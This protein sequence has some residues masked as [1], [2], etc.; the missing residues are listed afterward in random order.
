MNWAKVS[1]LLF[2]MTIT[3]GFFSIIPNSFGQN[4]DDSDHD[5]IIDI[6]DNCP[7]TP[8]TSQE[9]TDENGIGDA[10]QDVDGD[11]ILDLEDN[12]PFIPNPTQ[13]DS[14]ENGIGDACENTDLLVV[15]TFPPGD[16]IEI[17]IP[18]EPDT[19][20]GTFT[21]S[22]E[23]PDEDSCVDAEG[24]P[25]DCKVEIEITDAGDTSA[26]FS[27]LGSIINFT[28][29]CT[30]NC[31]I[32]FTFTQALLDEQG[33]TLSEVTIFHDMNENGSF[34][35]D[36]AIPTEVTDNGD[37]TFT[38]TASASFTSKF[39]VGGIKVLALGA[40]VGGGSRGG[41]PPSLE[42]ISFSGVKQ[43]GDEN[44]IEF[45]GILIDE[46]SSENNLP[47]QTI[48]TGESFELRLPF[49]EDSGVRA[50]QH[51]AVYVLHNGDE[52]INDSETFVI[53]EPNQPLHIFDPHG[54][55][56]TVSVDTIEKSTY[57]IDVIFKMTF[58][59]PMNTSDIIVRS[60]DHH[61]R[62]SDVK[63]NQLIQVIESESKEKISFQTIFDD[64][65]PSTDENHVI[66]STDV[67]KEEFDG[68]VVVFDKEKDQGVSYGSK[69]PKWI[70][71]N[72]NWW[73]QEEIDDNDFVA[74]IHFLIESNL[75][76]IPEIIQ[77]QNVNG[78]VIPTWIKSNAGWW[79]EGHLS[80]DE[81]MQTIQ[82]LIEERI[83]LL[84]SA[85][86]FDDFR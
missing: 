83:I 24:L 52:T 30:N 49:Y 66:Q 45:G 31:E 12:C 57:D 5:N 60:W 50:I 42:S 85:I 54:Y 76:K 41:S 29:P 17:E 67:S 27:F 32:S 55:T 13:D 20:T 59:I 40:L 36:E 56:S 47:T 48:E 18:E 74:G 39:S 16:T 65:I 62:S 6:D 78:Q 7:F 84:F 61:K 8:N 21:I 44:T 69:I 25:V 86:P 35:N 10:C 70:K 14:N 1:L 3:V 72:A 11:E 81:F 80:D 23:L 82:W 63:F 75:I 46:I 26:D 43:I 68:S 37:G 64:S 15:A 71:Y 53:Y 38:A 2:S 4:P 79:A 28:A 34:E 73:S 51:V 77:T 19:E 9:D 58:Q 33:I 22:I